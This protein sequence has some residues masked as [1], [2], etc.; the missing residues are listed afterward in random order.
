MDGK[1]CS[2]AYLSIFLGGSWIICSLVL[3]AVFG[4]FYKLYV[5]G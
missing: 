1:N 3:S 5:L 2:G 4:K